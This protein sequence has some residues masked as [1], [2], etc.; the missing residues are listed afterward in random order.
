MSAPHRSKRKPFINITEFRYYFDLFLETF[1]EGGIQIIQVYTHSFLHQITKYIKLKIFF[2]SA[3]LLGLSIPENSF[4][5][6]KI[7]KFL[8]WYHT[9]ISAAM[10]N[11]KK[12]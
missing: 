7:M 12:K 1:G 9:N 8:G 10:F 2:A 5:C 4:G 3:F 6:S 11:R